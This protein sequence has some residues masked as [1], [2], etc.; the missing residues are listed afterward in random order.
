MT[1]AAGWPG[2]VAGL[3]GQPLIVSGVM[4]YNVLGG[5]AAKTC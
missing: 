1:D 2:G 3:R 5:A 4:R